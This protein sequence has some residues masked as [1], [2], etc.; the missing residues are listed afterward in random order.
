MTEQATLAISASAT[1]T[2]A[3]PPEPSNPESPWGLKD[4]FRW[5]VSLLRSHNTFLDSHIDSQRTVTDLRQNILELARLPITAPIWCDHGLEEVLK[6]PEDPLHP[7]EVGTPNAEPAEHAHDTEH[8]Q[9]DETDD[10]PPDKRPM[11]SQAWTDDAIRQALETAQLQH[12][13]PSAAKAII[14]PQ[15]TAQA[16]KQRPPPEHK[17]HKQTKATK[18]APH[19]PVKAMPPNRPTLTNTTYKQQAK[20][21]PTEPHAPAPKRRRAK[22]SPTMKHTELSLEDVN[23]D[24]PEA[25]AEEEIFRQLAKEDSCTTNS[26]SRI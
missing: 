24:N 19:T 1:P 10:T 9:Q 13:I 14:H 7:P 6:P 20:N 18:T 8:A 25:F 17:T 16:F 5:L 21:T 3:G 12:A 11:E 26:E 15:K 2:R 23:T 22:T 4:T